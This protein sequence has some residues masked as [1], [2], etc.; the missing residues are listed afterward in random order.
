MELTGWWVIIPLSIAALLTGL[1]MSLGTRWGLFRHYWVLISL[2]LTVLCTVVLLLH[3]PTVS[4]MASVARNVDG[5]ELRAL[6]G[7]LFHPG[8]G[9]LLLLLVAG[10]NVYKPAGLTACGWR[11]QR[12]ERDLV[13]ASAGPRRSANEA[14]NPVVREAGKRS[15]W[16]IRAT[17]AATFTFH[18]AEMWFAMLVG[19]AVFMVVTIVT[20]ARGNALVPEPTS[21]EFQVAMSL[22]MVAPMAAWMRIRGCDWRECGEISG[23]MLLSTAAVLVL[24]VLQLS[25]AQ[26]WVSSNQHTLMLVSML[27]VMLYRRDHYTRGYSFGRWASCNVAYRRKGPHRPR[28]GRRTLWQ[29]ARAP[30]SPPR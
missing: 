26:L 12:K 28:I 11:K 13:R 18:F 16:R 7:D 19:M 2:G 3:M 8:A 6:G 24:G 9:L 5:A 15:T 14:A 21:I 4:A 25:G 20:S 30:G 29:H 10:L 17:R 22:F 1:V 23:A 27:A